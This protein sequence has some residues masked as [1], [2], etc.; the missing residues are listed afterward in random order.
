M[1]VLALPRCRSRQRA[2]ALTLEVIVALGVL[3]T[4]MS[5]TLPLIVR[6]DR[7][8]TSQRHY[9]LALDELSNQMDRLTSLPLDDLSEELDRLAPS[10]FALSRLPDAE[11]IG[12]LEPTDL[13]QL[14]KLQMTWHE[15]ERRAAPL[16]LVAWIYPQP[17]SSDEIKSAQEKP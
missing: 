6:H 17:G 8:L 10:S 15:S 1:N 2:G 14:L 13:G 7:L 4:T 9:R 5:V 11:I 12:Q 3:T 16:S